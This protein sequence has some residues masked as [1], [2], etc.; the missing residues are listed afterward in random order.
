MM[1]IIEEEGTEL[2]TSY[3]VDIV[4]IHTIHVLTY[5]CYNNNNNNNNNND[6][7]NNNNYIYIFI[8]LF[9]FYLFIY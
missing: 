2:I 8:Y 5:S 4:I 7:N 6:N 1:Q 3:R 9:F